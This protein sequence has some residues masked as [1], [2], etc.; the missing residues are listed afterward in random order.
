MQNTIKSKS[1]I[2]IVHI[3]YSCGLLQ[4]S[5]DLASQVQIPTVVSFGL[6]SIHF[7][8]FGSEPTV[9]NSFL[10]SG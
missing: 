5:G 6:V 2:E 4:Q 1:K 7:L 9:S 8:M 10:I 3:V